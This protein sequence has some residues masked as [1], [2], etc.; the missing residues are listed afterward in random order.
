MESRKREE[1][2]EALR[3]REA[4]EALRKLAVR[5]VLD[6]GMEPVAVADLLD[7]EADWVRTWVARYREGGLAA[8][9]DLP[10]SGRPAL[11][12]DF[13]VFTILW[14]EY[15]TH[16]SPALLCDAIEAETGVRYHISSVRRFLRKFGFSRKRPTLVHVNRAGPEEVR[17][18]QDSKIPEL[19]GLMSEG[20]TLLVQDESVFVNDAGK[21]AKHWSP[22]GERV[23]APYTGSH[24]KFAVFGA[25]AH[26]G[27]QLFRTYD[28]FDSPTFVRYLRELHR[29]F[30]RI[31]VIVDQASQHRAAVVRDYLEGCGG[32]VLL[33]ELPVGSPFMNASEGAWKRTKH[34]VRDPGCHRSVG[35]MRAAVGECP[36]VT[37]H[38]PGIFAYLRR[39]AVEFSVPMA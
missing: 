30:G 21:G 8:L 13:D 29:K 35:D 26:D 39:K 4:N 34:V 24:G 15:V 7:R 27:R 1:L 37:R 14:G 36:R 11:V 9:R 23:Y 28:W 10:R 6:R 25:L 16:V 3:E 38:H 2:R 5:L 22:V 31:A 18:W 19:L 12:P 33:Y 17:E 32:E 20:Y